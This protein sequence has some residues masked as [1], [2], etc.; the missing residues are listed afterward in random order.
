M[1]RV[2]SGWSK[3]YEMP[4][5]GNPR[6][7]E[8]YFIE[9]THLGDFR[10]SNPPVSNFEIPEKSPDTETKVSFRGIIKSKL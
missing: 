1:N 8:T 7:W 4:L 5:P 6:F 3:D 9:N 2:P 10:K